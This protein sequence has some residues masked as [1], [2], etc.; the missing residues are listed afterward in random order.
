MRSDFLAISIASGVFTPASAETT[1]EQTLFSRRFFQIADDANRCVLTSG[2]PPMHRSSPPALASPL[3]SRSLCACNLVNNL[4]LC[5]SPC[6]KSSPFFF[7]LFVKRLV[8]CVLSL[9]AGQSG[10]VSDQLGAGTI[11]GRDVAAQ[12]RQTLSCGEG[13]EAAR[14]EHMPPP[15]AWLS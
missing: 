13:T 11:L 1:A 7:N 4:L 5:A 12:R 3:S 8:N 14:A 2:L 10:R 15:C 9:T 6:D